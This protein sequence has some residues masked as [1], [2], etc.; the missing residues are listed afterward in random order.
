MLLGSWGQG[1]Q[2]LLV[3]KL[4]SPY[5]SPAQ[6]RCGY[7]EMVREVSLAIPTFTTWASNTSFQKTPGVTEIP[8]KEKQQTRFKEKE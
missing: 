6:R 5:Y 4:L 3:R 8:R 7:R 1:P 2:N